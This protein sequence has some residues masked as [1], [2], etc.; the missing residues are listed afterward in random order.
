MVCVP[1]FFDDLNEIFGKVISLQI[2]RW[3]NDQLYACNID[4]DLRLAAW[5]IGGWEVAGISPLIVRCGLCHMVWVVC[6]TVV[7]Q[8]LWS[9]NVLDEEVC[10][11]HS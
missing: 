11:L 3:Y 8:L 9:G 1:D 10:F 2:S 7:V 4:Y 6:E 5:C